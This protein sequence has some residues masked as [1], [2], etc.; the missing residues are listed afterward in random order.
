LVGAASFAACAVVSAVG[1]EFDVADEL[2]GD[3]DVGV[4]VVRGDDGLVAVPGDSDVDDVGAGFEGAVGLDGGVGVG[5]SGRV[6]GVVQRL[7]GWLGGDSGLPAGDGRDSPDALVGPLV[8]V[9]LREVVELGL[10]LGQ[11]GGEGLA[12][13][14][15]FEGLVEAFDAPMFVK[16]QFG[17]RWVGMCGWWRGGC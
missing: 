4:A 5:V 16:G 14:P 8:V 1:V 7:G 17:A 6:D 2:A 13:Q 11:V 10:E 12:A 15:A 3:E 9:E